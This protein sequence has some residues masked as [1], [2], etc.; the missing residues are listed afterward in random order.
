MLIYNIMSSFILILLLLG[1]VRFIIKK[2]VKKVLASVLLSAILFLILFSIG[3]LSPVLR[4]AEFNRLVLSSDAPDTLPRDLS[5]TSEILA[6][7]DYFMIYRKDD[8][9]FIFQV[10]KSYWPFL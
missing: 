8:R 7:Q 2:E 5:F 10:S 1:I 6:D 9:Y 4:Q 3:Q